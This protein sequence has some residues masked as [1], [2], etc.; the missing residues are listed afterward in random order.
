MPPV[1]V[2]FVRHGQTDWNAEL[3]F[4]GRQDVPLNALGRSQADDNGRK[5]AG[6]LEGADGLD[7]ISS[8]LSR[9]KETMERVRAAMGLARADYRIDER[10]IEASYGVLEGV[11]LAEFKAANRELHRYRK[12]NRWTFCP[13]GGESH[14]MTLTRVAQWHDELQRDAVVAA[15]GVV[16]RVLRYH[17]LALDPE[18]AGGFVFP[19]DK[20]LVIRRGE[21]EFV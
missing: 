14:E 21:E 11:T 10:L 2:Y 13:Q 5:L 3:R 9:A 16:G 18:E 4:Q 7:F 8:P 1:T 17:L 19:Q 6:L 15:H 20:V 12:A